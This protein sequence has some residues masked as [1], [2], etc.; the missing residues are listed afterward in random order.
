MKPKS[1][2]W[3]YWLIL[4]GLLMMVIAYFVHDRNKLVAEL[5]R[6]DS[7][8]FQA[9]R[10]MMIDH[11]R[12]RDFLTRKV[13]DGYHLADSIKLASDHAIDSLSRSAGRTRVKIVPVLVS[14]DSVCLAQVHYRDTLIKTQDSTIS[15]LYGERKALRVA[16]DTIEARWERKDRSS[17]KTIH[18]LADE[19]YRQSA[20]R[21]KAEKK[22]DNP[23]SFGLHAGYGATMSGGQVY[24]GPQAG[25]SVQYKIRLRKRR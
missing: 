12:E 24:M 7:T 21:Q 11:V 22:L 3:K 23:W 20:A 4:V 2:G 14:S 16:S 5:D 6:R 1:N 13:N 19:C 9:G 18:Q 17:E 10:N 15:T 8:H 25:A